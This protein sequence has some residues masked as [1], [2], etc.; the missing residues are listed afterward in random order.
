VSGRELS[1]AM[2]FERPTIEALAQV[3]RQ[4]SPVPVSSL[5]LINPAGSKPPLF[6]VHAQGGGAVAYYDL[7]HRLGNDQPFYGLEPPGRDGQREPLSGIP[8]MAAHYLES[9]RRVQPEGPY[10]LGGH[11]FGGLV[12]FEMATQLRKQGTEVALLAILDT[13]APVPGNTVFN[14]EGFIDEWD[15]AMIVVSLAKIVA[16]VVRKDLEISREELTG[17]DYEQR[18]IYFLEKLKK[19]DFVSP[20]EGPSLV[21]G[22]LAVERAMAKARRNYLLQG[23]VYP[24]L[25]TLFLSADIAPEDFRAR[26]RKLRD[27]PALGWGELVSGAIETHIVPGDHISMLNHPHVQILA[28]KLASCLDQASRYSPR[29]ESQSA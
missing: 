27:D 18:L 11:S 7:A 20:E 12:A 5:V 3:L 9:L 2:L 23:Q 17:L 22:L 14:P 16:R 15:D 29:K 24:G 25:M 26:D 19:V 21:R 28:Q 6:F 8:E 1:L 13:G 10:R 4:Q